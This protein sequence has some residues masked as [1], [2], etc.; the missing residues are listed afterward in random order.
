MKREGEITYRIIRCMS[1]QLGVR[2]AEPNIQFIRSVY[3]TYEPFTGKRLPE[4]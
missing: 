4:V 3:S 1:E 2:T